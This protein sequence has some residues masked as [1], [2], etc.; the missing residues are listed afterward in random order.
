[1]FTFFIKEN[2]TIALYIIFVLQIVY[3]DTLQTGQPLPVF[4]SEK[5]PL[6]DALF[7]PYTVANKPNLQQNI[8]Q[9]VFN[10]NTYFPRI[11]LPRPN[12]FKNLL[13]PSNLR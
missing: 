5:L 3:S 1:M 12:F 6:E 13:L 7:T 4:S 2:S 9:V 10:R 8:I 11:L